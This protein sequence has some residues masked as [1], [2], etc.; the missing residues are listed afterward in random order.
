MFISKRF[1]GFISEF[2]P[3]PL[4]PIFPN[5]TQTLLLGYFGK[6]QKSL[7][8]FQFEPFPTGLSMLLNCPG[9]KSARSLRHLAFQNVERAIT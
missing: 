7:F 5:W 2:G 9:L 4:D 3:Y 1:I 6:M 8:A